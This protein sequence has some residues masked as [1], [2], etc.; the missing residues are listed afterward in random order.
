MIEP[1]NV[2]LRILTLKVFLCLI[3]I[4]TMH[5]L[6]VETYDV[7]ALGKMTEKPFALEIAKDELINGGVRDYVITGPIQIPFDEI[8]EELTIEQRIK[9]VCE[10]YDVPYDLA[11][12]I[13]RLETGW[14][15]S[16]AYINKNNVGGLSK[17]GKLMSFN[18]LNEGVEAFISNLARNYIAIGLTT[19]EEIGKKYCPDNAEWAWTIR[20]LMRRENNG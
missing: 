9:N 17:K 4:I 14:F 16:N 15:K 2:D 5:M 10:Y 8:V 3:S 18:S 7:R 12:S 20:K 11:I 6:F 19:P 13:A 1:Q